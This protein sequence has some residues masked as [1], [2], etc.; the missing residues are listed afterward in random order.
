MGSGWSN[1][2]WC[3]ACGCSCVGGRTECPPA[4][5]Y[6]II[7]PGLVGFRV[8]RAFARTRVDARPRPADRGRQTRPFPPAPLPVERLS[9][10][11]RS[12]PV[13][14]RPRGL[15]PPS[16]RSPSEGPA[17]PLRHMRPD[18]LATIFRLHLLPE[19]PRAAGVGCRRPGGGE[20]SPADRSHSGLC[21]VYRYEVVGSTRTSGLAVAGRGAQPAPRSRRAGRVRSLRDLRLLSGRSCRR[22]HRGRAAFVVCLR[23]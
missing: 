21:P 7:H 14:F 10:A 2:A 5:G 23:L 13:P 6:R 11:P 22:G 3:S 17:L 19:T 4:D 18:V 8:G 9:E 1:P 20:C 12:R 15:L 16:L